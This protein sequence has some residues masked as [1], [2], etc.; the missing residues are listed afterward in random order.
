MQARPYPQAPNPKYAVT[1]ALLSF[2]VLLLPLFWSP[3][4]DQPI[5]PLARETPRTVSDLL[6]PQEPFVGPVQVQALP[7]TAE[8]ESF[9]TLPARQQPDPSFEFAGHLRRAV[10]SLLLVVVLIGVTLKALQRYLPALA[11]KRPKASLFEVVARE[12]VGQGQS[13]ALVRVGS[14]LLLVGMTEQ[15]MTTL[16]EFSPSEQGFLEE[17]ESPVQVDTPEAAKVYGDIL[18]HYLS[19][20]P[21]MGAKK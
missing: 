4:D 16:C 11:G 1:F 17:P 8:E 3:V 9:A 10:L 5:T 19:I 21:G 6:A 12:Q 7:S 15:S 18:K 13:L 20:V 14:K 2:C